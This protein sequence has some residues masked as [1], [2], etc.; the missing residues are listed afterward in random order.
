MTGIDRRVERVRSGSRR[1]RDLAA[2]GVPLRDERSR[3]DA[4][5]SQAARAVAEA[6]RLDREAK[7]RP[8][9]EVPGRVDDYWADVAA[10][11]AAVVPESTYRLWLEP[12]IAIGEID[13]ALCVEASGSDFE[14]VELH[15]ASLIG[16]T[17]RSCTDYRGVFLFR[18]ETP[19]D[20]DEGLH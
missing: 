9:I 7:L 3:R 12:L 4:E 13:G 17:V 5:R 8:Q 1:K 20:P 6:K 2:V 16:E 19:D 14:W 10:R 11:L 18:A 15:Y